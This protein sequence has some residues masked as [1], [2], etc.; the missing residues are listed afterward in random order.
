MTR[1]FRRRIRRVLVDIDT[2]YDLFNHSAQ[3]ITV[4]LRRIRRLMAWARVQHIPVIS[5]ALARPRPENNVI[6]PGSLNNCMEG[7]FG[8]RKIS[9]TQLPTRIR[10]GAENRLDLPRNLLGQY[11]QIIFEK[12][13]EDPFA[14]PRA[15]RLLTELKIEE[16]ILFGMGIDKAIKAAALGLLYRRKQVLIVTDAVNSADR[17]TT[18][19]SLRQMEAKGARLVTTESLTGKSRLV[20]PVVLK[21]PPASVLSN[22]R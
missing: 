18:I 4:L 7:T 13:T 2:Q 16:F 20:G 14:H 21:S 10:F 15:D 19:M 12:R 11:Q 6:P 3:D 9:Y 1:L 5:T 17:R 22:S 8:Q